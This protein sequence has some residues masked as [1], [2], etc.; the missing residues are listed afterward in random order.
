MI[1]AKL[2]KE[3]TKGTVIVPLSAK[4]PELLRLY[5]KNLHQYLKWELANNLSYLT[6]LN[7]AYTLQI[8]REQFDERA[9]FVVTDIEQLL[10]SVEAFY[11]NNGIFDGIYTGS[12]FS[13][14]KE[15]RITLEGESG[16]CF[17]QLLLKNNEVDKLAQLWV[18]GVNFDWNLLYKNNKPSRVPLS[19][20]TFAR[21]RYW[22]INDSVKK[23]RENIDRMLIPKSV[24][25]SLI[26]ENISKFSSYIF[27]KSFNRSEFFIKEHNFGGKYIAPG[28]VHL[29]MARAAY[30]LLCD[31]DFFTKRLKDIVF[32]YPVECSDQGSTVYIS[33]KPDTAGVAFDIYSNGNGNGM[34]D[35][36]IVH[37]KGIVEQLNSLEPENVNIQHIRS[38][39][40]KQ[41]DP[42]NFYA[43]SQKIGANWQGSFQSI[44]EMYVNDTEALSFLS[45]KEEQDSPM[46]D[47]ILHPAL[48]DGAMQTVAAWLN[49]NDDEIVKTGVLFYIGQLDIFRSLPNKCYV[50]IIRTDDN[51]TMNISLYDSNGLALIKIHGM[52]FKEVNLQAEGKGIVAIRKPANNS[53]EKMLYSTRWYPVSSGIP[54]IKTVDFLLCFSDTTHDPGLYKSIANQIVFVRCGKQFN[55]IDHN[56]YEINLTVFSDY[57][58]LLSELVKDKPESTLYILHQWSKQDNDINIMNECVEEYLDKGVRSLFHITKALMELKYIKKVKL[59]YLHYTKNGYGSSLSSISSGFMKTLIQENPNYD[60]RLVRLDEK[61]K[62]Q[63]ELV[64]IIM[65]EFNSTDEN[66]VQY[67]NSRREIKKIFPVKKPETVK[68]LFKESGV[69]LITGGTGGL[70]LIF[71]RYLAETYHAVLALT[72]RSPLTEDKKKEIQ[73]LSELG[74]KA[75]YIQVDAADR[76]AFDSKLNDFRKRYGKISGVLHS[77]GIIDDNYIVKK[78]LDSFNK[79]LT[80]KIHGTLILDEIT[81][82]DDLDF[83]VLF[84][85]ITSVLGNEGQSDYAAANT[86]M[87]EFVADRARMVAEGKRK[88]HSVSINWSLWYNGGMKLT[89]EY[90]MYL[91]HTKK[92]MPLTNSG[93]IEALIKILS[94]PGNN[95]IVYDGDL[96][97]YISTFKYGKDSDLKTEEQKNTIEN[98]TAG[99][100]ASSNQGIVKFLIEVIAKETKLPLKRIKPDMEFEK[101]GIDSLMIMNLTSQI[102]KI[103]GKVSKT[104]FFEYTNVLSLAEFF[105]KEFPDKVNSILNAGSDVSDINESKKSEIAINE[106]FERNKAI[107]G[108]YKEQ[109]EIQKT[110][111]TTSDYKSAIL[112]AYSPITVPP[113]FQSKS[114]KQ[115]VVISMETQAHKPDNTNNKAVAI[116]GLAGR[117]PLADDINQYWNNLKEGKD[118]I[119][120]IPT[121]RWDYREYY[122]EQ[123]GKQGK[124]YSKWGGFINNIDKFDPLF[125]N[126][127]PREAN[128]LDPHER[129]FLEI[130]W[131]TVEDAGY[132]LQELK[133]KYENNI[134]VF[135]GATWPD[136][137]L[138]A[139]DG[140]DPLQTYHPEIHLFNISNRVSYQLGLN[141]P[142]IAVDTACSSAL[143][144]IHL[145]VQN[146]RLGICKAAIAGGVNLSLHVNK[147]INLAQH[148]FLSTDG[149]CRSFGKDGDGYV[150]GEGVGAILLKNFDDA[151]RDCDTIYG[152]I[153]GTA[154]NHGGRTNGYTVPNPNAQADLIKMALDD[155][156]IDP[157]S[158][159]YVE[160]HGT[161]TSLGDPIEIRG[162]T[163]AFSF[164]SDKKQFCAI[165][166][167]KSNIGHLEAAA[168]IAQV[169]KVLLQMKNKTL[170]P[171]IHARELNPNIDFA[172]TP[173]Y[174]QHELAPWEKIVNKVDNKIITYPRRSGVSSFGAGGSNAHII[175]EE[176]EKDHSQ[177]LS[178]PYDNLNNNKNHL[179]ILS[180]ENRHCLK[181]YAGNLITFIKNDGNQYDLGDIAY[182]LQIG[183]I[184][185]RDRLAIIADSKQKLINTLDLFIKNNTDNTSEGNIY[186]SN[187]Q[188]QDDGKLE[189]N[190]TEDIKKA[191]IKEDLKSLAL[192]WIKHMEIDWK[193]LHE[194]NLRYRIS[195]PTYP[196]DKE[197]YWVSKDNHAFNSDVDIIEKNLHSMIDSNISTINSCI[198]SKKLLNKYFFLNDHV[199]NNKFVLPGVAYLEM[200]RAA[201]TL[202]NPG[203]TVV[204]LRNVSWITPLAVGMQERTVFIHLKNQNNEI[205]YEIMD[206]KNF[207]PGV[208]KY[209]QGKIIY[210]KDFKPDQPQ[211]TDIDDIKRSLENKMASDTFYAYYGN[212]GLVYGKTFKT[213]AE[214]FYDNDLI[215][216]KL[217]LPDSLSVGDFILHPGLLDGALQIIAATENHRGINK[218]FLP[219]SLGQ[220][221]ILDKIP[222]VC[223]S[224]ARKLQ[225]NSENIRKYDVTIYDTSGK[226]IVDIKDFIVC[227]VD[228]NFTGVFS[229][230]NSSVLNPLIDYKD[231]ELPGVYIKKFSRDDFFLRDHL[232]G[233]IPVLPA[234][235]YLEMAR[236]VAET[237]FGAKV[238][239]IAN[240]TWALPFEV[241]NEHKD[242]QVKIEKALD[243]RIE[244]KIMSNNSEQ[245]V[246]NS[247][248][249]IVLIND[250]NPDKKAINIEQLRKRINQS[251]DPMKLYHQLDS[252]GLNLGKTMQSMTELYV[253]EN[254][255]FSHLVLPESLRN[256]N[257]FVLHPSLMAGALGTEIAIYPDELQNNLYLPFSIDELE[258]YGSLPGECFVYAYKHQTASNDIRK[259]EI[260]ILNSDG[261]ILAQ[262]VK[263]YNR[264]IDSDVIGLN[265]KLNLHPMYFSFDWQQETLPATNTGNNTIIV[266]GKN[267]QHLNGLFDNNLNVVTIKEASVYTEIADNEYEIN[268]RKQADY[269]TL[270]KSLISKNVILNNILFL[271]SYNDNKTD[272]A[273]INDLDDE[274][275]LGIY[276]LFMLSK[277]LIALEVK[278]EI[279]LLYVQY[280]SKEN[281]QPQ[282]SAVN[283]FMNSLKWEHPNM[284]FTLLRTNQKYNDLGQIIKNSVQ[285]LTNADIVSEIKYNDNER[286]V[287]K[288]KEISPNSPGGSFLRD[289]GVYTISGGTG[290]LGFIFARMI[291]KECN[292][293]L[294]LLGRSEYNAEKEKLVK[295]IQ[296]LGSEAI[297]IQTDISD[298][299]SIID[300]FK[301]IKNRFGE[302]NGVIHAAG[303]INDSYLK[304]K[305]LESFKQVLAPKIQGVINLD[306]ATKDEALDFFALFSSATA[307]WG[308]LG[309]TDYS[310]GNSFLD[311]FALYRNALIKQEK[312]RG[313]TVSFSWPLWKEGGM[314]VDKASVE[315][316]EKI[317]G[318]QMLSTEQGLAAFNYWINKDNAH[319][320]VMAGNREKIQKVLNI[321]EMIENPQIQDSSPDKHSINKESFMDETL[322]NKFNE[323]I[324]HDL[325]SIVMEITGVKREKL[326]PDSDINKFG[327]DSVTLT[328]LGNK[329]NKRFGI[330]ITP[331]TFFEYNK[332]NTISKHLAEDY[333]EKIMNIYNITAEVKGLPVKTMAEQ[334]PRVEIFK[335][336]DEPQNKQF[337]DFSNN[338]HEQYEDDIAIIG[339]A[340]I[341]PGANNLNEYW[342]VLKNEKNCIS[343]IPKKRFDWEQ[344]YNEK[345]SLEG[346][347]INTKW[348]GFIEDIDAFDADFMGI[349]PQEAE[350]MDP[351]QRKLLE[352]V[353]HTLEDAGYSP[354]DVA[355]SNTG[356]F[357]GVEGVDYTGLDMIQGV[358]PNANPYSATGIGL[359]LVA[360]RISYVYNFHGPSE[361]ISTACS[362]SLTSV[363]AAIKAIKNGDC[364]MAIAGGVSA[365]LTPY[366]YMLL[367]KLG[368]LSPDGACRTF[369]KDANGYVRGEGVGT[370]LLKP[371]SKAINDNDNI[372]AVIK[373]IAVNHGGKANSITSPNVALQAELIEKAYK[374]AGISPDT[375]TYIEAHGT[376]TRLGDPVEI[377]SL[378]KAF[379]KLYSYYGKNQVNK[380]YCGLGSVKTN[381][382]HLEPA[383]SV[384]SIIKVILS[385]RNGILPGTVHFNEI[386]PYIK[387]DDSP[388]YIVKNTK[389]WER[390]KDQ[391]GKVIPRRAGISGFGYG[392][393]YAHIVLEEYDKQEK[394]LQENEKEIII[395]SAKDEIQ[396]YRYLEKMLEFIRRINKQTDTKDVQQDELLSKILGYMNEELSRITNLQNNTIN[397]WENLFEQ[398][399]DNFAINKLFDEINANW[400]ILIKPHDIIYEANLEKIAVHLIQYHES[401]L[402]NIFN[403][404]DKQETIQ[405]QNDVS[406]ADI[407]YTLQVGRNCFN[408]RIAIIAENFADLTSK[409][410]QIM[411]KESIIENVYICGDIRKKSDISMWLVGEPGEAFINSLIKENDL[412]KIAKLWV[413]GLNIDWKKMNS[414]HPHNKIS[415]PGYEFVKDR[416]WMDIKTYDRQPQSENIKIVSHDNNASIKLGTESKADQMEP[417]ESN[418]QPKIESAAND[419]IQKIQVYI[420]RTI[421]ELLKL[422]EDIDIMENF[423]DLGLDSISLNSLLVH[424]QDKLNISISPLL[425]LE[426]STLEA[427][428]IKLANDYHQEFE[429]Y[430]NKKN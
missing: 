80:P 280:E 208:K 82:K 57:Q 17:L 42:Q 88:G 43:G 209:S 107:S 193:K 202:A 296:D 370:I 367:S 257:Q 71:A 30:D 365:L 255:A 424:F 242:I 198:F 308:N 125:F 259:G 108:K 239:K 87:D 311:S 293:K 329:I 374:R 376:G 339:A 324:K 56:N 353:W 76:D 270:F 59:L 60:Y 106:N 279:R 26:D 214:L 240:I 164:S 136:Y 181:E 344:Y 147:Y 390:T 345:P 287:K 313:K 117:Y 368:V 68:N 275:D 402:K 89:E 200:A 96:D 227:E 12:V 304:N 414:N 306:A 197:S 113:V 179:I 73:N 83:F 385:M 305:S 284:K 405:K 32:G 289:K 190:I 173:F 349:S 386:N 423:N 186:I 359:S 375:I 337:V 139:I 312:R 271:W 122:D 101:F 319:I 114:Y 196:F 389:K 237:E 283:G 260:Y 145:A 184:A 401:A 220:I 133:E 3:Q 69:Y 67:I 46:T 348:G 140:N 5:A 299:K 98:N 310:T 28:A 410:T 343:Q 269:T 204:C 428:S 266:F 407:A 285:E 392:G 33:L 61:I 14:N 246:V 336:K 381:I 50:H 52:R 430:F 232:V 8:G 203:D 235:V 161:G 342:D 77:A 195:L 264:K 138:Y 419:L 212:L 16:D 223:Y 111:P 236:V 415:L 215:L 273:D 265:N 391:N 45:L 302:I 404:S 418:N 97:H 316:M 268:Y 86:F 247:T 79:V 216:A 256:D 211:Q 317:S 129:L 322:M 192:F 148:K 84:S 41:I 201:G 217:R 11:Q 409:L 51:N 321:N 233:N 356:V 49:R 288:A 207:G 281:I 35:S 221:V 397:N 369:D 18:T 141:G 332:I 338:Q 162:L 222:E 152:V 340:G 309:Q 166:S 213:V 301:N 420:V 176:Y 300:G 160:A 373:G 172:N 334:S 188:E 278:D 31:G 362:S 103:F 94:L 218:P 258:I 58:K 78:T 37:S 398:G 70:G 361:V 100:I 377:N 115:N 422:K 127:S 335:V 326:D 159:S 10:K 314:I 4:E 109:G 400:G 426:Y 295:E 427:L 25:H 102:E 380:N 29:E 294:A 13:Q 48:I 347:D 323:K 276:S 119:T 357:I 120:E 328:E 158:I 286:Y 350:L 99:T 245:M 330:E 15:A 20:Y 55:Q 346:N 298:P 412:N 206:G 21:E 178:D 210:S 134:G 75:E 394:E 277:A 387:I 142:S 248:G 157:A 124:T 74:G 429:I 358:V 307:V 2:T 143:T 104:L 253:T 54:S 23:Q 149:R 364:D 318:M 243:N 250:N 229:E 146:L 22:L 153:R 408:S 38:R 170:V 282:H 399:I 396:L 241:D 383:A 297:Y 185:L 320:L 34:E 112:D 155:A 341:F 272:L 425:L 325:S 205:H 156:D 351:Q 165:G 19:T 130:A 371:L 194:N 416:H 175:I 168:G 363:D 66:D 254:E 224:V 121:D 315:M 251:Q 150:P 53:P 249:Q 333:T 226:C 105:L 234:V 327:F 63:N 252:L 128:L 331:A 183:R 1:T 352:T 182:T 144:A 413:Y 303:I 238:F 177:S 403:I 123:P 154:V 47:F 187:L 267:T 191:L 137:Q 263:I 355:D 169:T 27:K 90:I 421:R 93:G 118:C 132:T 395:F 274:L 151:V 126:I 36:I 24:L 231:N 354:A 180:A 65:Q 411:K 292:V 417:A 189:K 116:I 72:G 135:I 9:A 290:G 199:V 291:A 244:F 384:A 261:I 91:Q 85:S 174:V 81:R 378:K 171:S 225:T 228:V 131:K 64:S 110:N 360:N 92:L 372:Y 163:K 6:L 219:Y 393:A 39:M 382:G 95:V 230:T 62:D 379:E 262:I 167:S 40:E 388:F 366:F 7:I 406:L 44:K